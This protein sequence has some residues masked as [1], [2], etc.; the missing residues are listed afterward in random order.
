MT[1]LMQ[2]LMAMPVKA[3]AAANTQSVSSNTSQRPVSLAVTDYYQDA[4]LIP[5]YAVDDVA[6]TTAAGIVVNYPDK[7]MLN[8]T[9]PAT[10][11]EVAA[12]IH[13]ALVSQGKAAPI[14]EQAA[15]QYV[16]GER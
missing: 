4:A 10:R 7:R 2:P 3:S 16:V 12:L 5:Q 11:G 1:T 13:Q 8:P 15:A 6:A 14:A 9:R